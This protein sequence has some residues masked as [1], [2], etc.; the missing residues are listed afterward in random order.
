M[1]KIPPW[2]VAHRSTALNEFFTPEEL[3]KLAPTLQVA[4]SK[5]N[6]V[7]QTAHQ[8]PLVVKLL[9]HGTVTC[10]STD[11]S[12]ISKDFKAE[13]KPHWINLDR[14]FATKKSAAFK[15]KAL[16]DTILV[17]IQDN[18]F[19]AMMQHSEKFRGS[20]TTYLA[21]LSMGYQAALFNMATTTAVSRIQTALQ[22]DLA[23]LKPSQIARRVG[24]SRE[25]VSRLLSLQ[26]RAE[27]SSVKT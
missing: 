14:V 2:V 7:I 5:R 6:S 10:Y 20:L 25:M 23:E 21:D 9:L 26:R 24:C 8:S 11:E 16:T 22:T 17:L 19:Y 1:S 27:E 3:E 18:E 13:D 12:F 15:L 4:S